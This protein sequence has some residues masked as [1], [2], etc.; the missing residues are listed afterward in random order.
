ML[1]KVVEGSEPA[2]TSEAADDAIPADERPYLPC[3]SRVLGLAPE[4]AP[5]APRGTLM[6][7]GGTILGPDEVAAMTAEIQ[8]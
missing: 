3:I 2:S 4:P 8:K 1:H 5:P 6:S 7:G